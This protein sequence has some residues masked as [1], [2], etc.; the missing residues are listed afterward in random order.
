MFL[1]SRIVALIGGLAFIVAS[2]LTWYWSRFQD[3]NAWQNAESVTAAVCLILALIALVVGW[4]WRNG[5]LAM[6]ILELLLLIVCFGM[7]IYFILDNQQPPELRFRR[8]AAGI[9]AGAWMGLG[10]SLVAMV[11]GILNLC[12]QGP[13]SSVVIYDE[14]QDYEEPR[15]RRPRNEDEPPRRR[16]PRPEQQ[17]RRR[18]RPRED[19][20]D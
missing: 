13:V 10:C 18:P 4:A 9:G 15:R 7:T 2:F 14:E 19:D 12:S 1:A 17:R 6:G 8:E 20:W 16:R 11:G 3:E 5:W